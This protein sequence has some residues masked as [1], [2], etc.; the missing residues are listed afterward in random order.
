M[1]DALQRTMDA[2]LLKEPAVYFRVLGGA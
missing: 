2:G 1:S